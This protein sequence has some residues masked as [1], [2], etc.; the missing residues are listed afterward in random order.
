MSEE[1]TKPGAPAAEV[2]VEK[3]NH[4]EDAGSAVEKKLEEVEKKLEV[5]IRKAPGT[6]LKLLSDVDNTV[7]RINKYGSTKRGVSEHVKLTVMSQ[8][9]C[10]ARRTCIVPFDLQLHPLH[11]RIRADEVAFPN[12]AS[13]EAPLP[14]QDLECCHK[15]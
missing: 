13:P 12:L 3:T 14:H 1:D 11:P 8:A 15:A 2:V 4:I 10:S 9:S 6:A 5:P 7:L